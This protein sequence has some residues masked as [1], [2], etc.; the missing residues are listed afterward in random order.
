MYAVTTNRHIQLPNLRP[1]H[2]V[3]W[4]RKLHHRHHQGQDGQSILSVFTRHLSKLLLILVLHFN[5]PGFDLA[6]KI[7]E[8]REPLGG[9][10]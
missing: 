8:W 2:E 3:I 5:E 6:L 7:V 1:N 4:R 9:V 10:E